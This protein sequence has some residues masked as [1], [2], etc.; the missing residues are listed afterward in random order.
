MKWMSHFYPFRKKGTM[1]PFCC[2]FFYIAACGFLLNLC[3]PQVEPSFVVVLSLDQT[4]SCQ[5]EPLWTSSFSLLS[6]M[7]LQA[8]LGLG[9]GPWINVSMHFANNTFSAKAQHRNEWSWQMYVNCMALNNMTMPFSRLARLRWSFLHSLNCLKFLV[10]PSPRAPS[11]ILPNV[12]HCAHDIHKLVQKF[13]AQSANCQ[14][15]YLP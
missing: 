11:S 4:W 7:L 10:K 2:C 3:L 12:L 5:A 9:L 13:K 6:Y 14:L 8:R 1:S 15:A